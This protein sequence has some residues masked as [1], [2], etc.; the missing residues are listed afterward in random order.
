MFSTLEIYMTVCSGYIKT[1][2]LFSKV[3]YPFNSEHNGILKRKYVS[4]TV[5]KPLMIFEVIS[6]SSFSKY[7]S[8]FGGYGSENS[9]SCF[10]GM[11]NLGFIPVCGVL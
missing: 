10:L 3:A 2:A 8:N 11:D 5:Y 1:D 7:H 9:A 6:C 4:P